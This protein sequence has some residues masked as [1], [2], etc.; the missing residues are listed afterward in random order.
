MNKNLYLITEIGQIVCI[1]SKGKLCF[2]DDENMK[3][4]RVKYSK[5]TAHIMR[6]ALEKKGI[7]TTIKK[8]TEVEK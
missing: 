8:I 3:N 4:R 5:L 7:K 6:K 1:D 2:S